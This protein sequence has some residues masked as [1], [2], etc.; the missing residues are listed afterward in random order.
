MILSIFD[1]FMF[2][3][4]IF[5]SE[6]PDINSLLELNDTIQKKI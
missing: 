2:H 3:T 6:S 4:K 1:S 5:P